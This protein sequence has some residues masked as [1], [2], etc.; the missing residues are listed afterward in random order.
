MKIL[1]FTEGTTIEYRKKIP[2]GNAPAKLS[3]WKAQGAEI[4]YLTSRTTPEE[5][6]VVQ[7]L[8]EQYEFPQGELFYRRKGEAYKDVAERV[9]P[10]L[11]IEDDCASIGGQI[12]MTYP[13]IKS[14][15]K[16]KI[17]SIVVVEDGGI[18]HLPDSLHDLI[19]Y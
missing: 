5:I 17:K 7:H 18:D 8:L 2:S 1:V 13:H 4:T 11:I 10:D 15:L 3:A 9:L 12:Q 16:S 6:G 14:E 19:K